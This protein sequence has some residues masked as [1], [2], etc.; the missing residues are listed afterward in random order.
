MPIDPSI[1]LQAQAPDPMKPLSSMLNIAQG[2][3]GMQAQKLQMTGQDQRNQQGA[4]DLQERQGLQGVLADPTKWQNQDG[5]TN[6]NALIPQVMK[7]APTTGMDVI[8]KMAQTERQATDAKQTIMNLGTNQRQLVGQY[9]QSLT[10]QPVDKVNEGL[11]SLTKQFP[12]LAPA[13]SY[14]KTVF[15]HLDK[16]AG[17][18]GV[19]QGLGRFAQMTMTP[20]EQQ[21][22]NTPNGVQVNDNQHAYTVNTKPGIPNTPQGAVVQGSGATIQPP[23]TT[24]VMGG[25]NGTQPGIMGP[26]TTPAPG[27]IAPAPGQSVNAA[28]HPA[29]SPQQQKAADQDKV[30]IYSQERQ[31]LATDLQQAQ[32]SGDPAAIA[33][34]QQA[35]AELEKEIRSQKVAMPANNFMPTGMAPGQAGNMENNTALM[36]DHYTK[37]SGN[38]SDAQ[39]ALGLTGNIKSLAEGA[40]TGTEAGRKAYVTGLLNTLHLGGQATGDLQKDTDLLEKNMA[41]L[42]LASPAATDA[43]RTLVSAARPHSTMSAGAIKEAA[44]QVGAQVQANLAVRNYLTPYKYANGGK[45]DPEGYQAARQQI[46]ST[47]DPRAWQ[48]VNLKPGSTEAKAFMSKLKPDDRAQLVQKIGHLEQMGMLK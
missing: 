32:K 4:I 3:Q 46:E 12:E 2:V 5:S 35:Q 18:Q 17:Q 27:Q 48:Y 16:T 41:Q 43:A 1:P 13:T 8:G 11:D 23:P 9:V 10:G 38:A 44:E 24:P 19:D 34:A 40:S 26:S 47:A 29:V 15:S 20:T 42:N 7:V 30:A 39:T 45:G 28:G 36:N 6:Y 14:A 33:R 22:Y 37:L 21:T 31:Q 25:A